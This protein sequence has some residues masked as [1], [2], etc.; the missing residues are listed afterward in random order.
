MYDQIAS[1]LNLT[2]GLNFCLI[3]QSGITGTRFCH[4]RNCYRFQLFQLLK[5]DFFE[6]DRYLVRP[7]LKFKTF[8]H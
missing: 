5:P 8:I 6:G 3:L 7:S 1:D 4:R 2:E